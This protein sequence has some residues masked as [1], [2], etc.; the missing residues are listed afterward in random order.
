MKVINNLHAFIWREARMNNCNTFFIDGK[1]KILIDPGHS[2]AFR[3]VEQEL[4]Q[5]DIRIDQID[6]VI[7]THGHPDHMEAAELFQK[8]TLIAMGEMGLPVGR[9]GLSTVA[10]RDVMLKKASQAGKI[11][12]SAIKAK[13]DKIEW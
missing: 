11:A 13:R 7:I 6:A 3:F 2:Q 10:V 4:A 5:L 9:K 12:T 1:K 8:P